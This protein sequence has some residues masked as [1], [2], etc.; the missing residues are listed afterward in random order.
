MRFQH[1]AFEPYRDEITQLALVHCRPGLAELN[2]LATARGLVNARHQP[3]CFTTPD[4]HLSARDYESRILASGCIP[5]R[6]DNWH[7]IMNALVWLRFPLFKAALNAAHG[8]ALAAETSSQRGQRRDALTVLDESGIWVTSRDHALADLLQQRQWHQLFWTQ[9]KQVQTDMQFVVVG[10]ALLE[11]ML[12]P[13]PA[14][15]GKC[16]LLKPSAIS[17]SSSGAAQAEAQAMAALALISTPSQFAPLPL[18]GIPG[19]DVANEHPDYY[20]NRTV[21]RGNTFSRDVLPEQAWRTPDQTQP[22]P[23]SP[24]STP[25]AEDETRYRK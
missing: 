24:T 20:D 17:G 4:G 13:Y 9:R 6:Y 10:H 12:S 1:P 2:A 19:W 22:D 8:A 23:V 15:T 5:T 14:M 7:D 16:L 21:F 3:L 25:S 18:F 11:K